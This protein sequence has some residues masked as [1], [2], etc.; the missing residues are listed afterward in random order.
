MSRPRLTAEQKREL[1]L[2]FMAIPRGKRGKWLEKQ[3]IAPRS[4]YLWR[5]QLVEG[6][7]ETGMI[8]RG[9]VLVSE[10]ENKEIVRLNR[11]IDRLKA[12]LEK[13][14]GV[15]ESQARAIDVLGKAIEFL[16]D[17]TA[18]KNSGDLNG[19]R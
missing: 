8:P 6:A 12:K 1:V 11:E 14:E 17:G 9:G 5:Q 3:D 15:S 4:F 19:R 13:A 10:A 18:S 2:E 7:I 16:Q